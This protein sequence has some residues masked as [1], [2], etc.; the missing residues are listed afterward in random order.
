VA[1]ATIP[2]GKSY[3]FG[4]RAEGY[5]SFMIISAISG[6]IA[7]KKFTFLTEPFTTGQNENLR[8]R[9][10]VKCPKVVWKLEAVD[11]KNI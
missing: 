5:S 9:L 4:E 1:R 10:Y 8:F 3:T 2:I 11:G 6:T 7:K